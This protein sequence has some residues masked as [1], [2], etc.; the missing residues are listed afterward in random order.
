MKTDF[1]WIMKEK[2]EFRNRRNIISRTSQS[3]LLL[4][5][6]EELLQYLQ[7]T[8]STLPIGNQYPFLT[9]FSFLRGRW[10]WRFTRSG[11]WA[12]S[13]FS[14]R[15]HNKGNLWRFRQYRGDPLDEWRLIDFEVC[16]P[17][18]SDGYFL[19]PAAKLRAQPRQIILVFP[20]SV[21]EH[22]ETERIDLVSPPLG[23]HRFHPARKRILVAVAAD[24]MKEGDHL[25]AESHHI[26]SIV[27][28]VF[29]FFGLAARASYSSDAV[30]LAP[31]SRLLYLMIFDWCVKP[32]SLSGFL[33]IYLLWMVPHGT[34]A[35]FQDRNSRLLSWRRHLRMIWCMDVY[36][37]PWGWIQWLIL[38][39]YKHNGEDCACDGMYKIWA[40]DSLPLCILWLG[41]FKPLS[42]SMQ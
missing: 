17:S 13:R 24:V 41:F 26:R 1:T 42:S 7:K 8:T 28:E 25:L 32:N 23:R 15:F 34:S 14:N 27:P 12:S 4:R 38:C 18:V 21:C 2:A 30:P 3:V 35:S 5:N 10:E 20:S 39:L 33:K 9:V 40:C 19:V 11:S 36:Y 37:P 16:Q 31:L 29:D 6:Q 22:D